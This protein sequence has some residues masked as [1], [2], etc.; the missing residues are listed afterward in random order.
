MSTHTFQSQGQRSIVALP[1]KIKAH[2]ECRPGAKSKNIAPYARGRKVI[3]KADRGARNIREPPCFRRVYPKTFGFQANQFHKLWVSRGRS[4][5]TSMFQKGLPQD[6]RVPSEPVPQTLGFSILESGCRFFRRSFS[7]RYPIMAHISKKQISLITAMQIRGQEFLLPSGATDHLQQISTDTSGLH[8]PNLR[9]LPSIDMQ[10]QDPESPEVIPRVRGRNREIRGKLVGKNH[11]GLGQ[12][13]GLQ[14][15]ASERQNA[16]SEQVPGVVLPRKAEYGPCKIK[17]FGF[18]QTSGLNITSGLLDQNPRVIKNLRVPMQSPGPEK[19][20]GPGK[21]K[22][23]GSYITPGSKRPSGLEQPPGSKRSPGPK[24]TSGFKTTSGFPHDHW[25]QNDLRVQNNLRV[26]K[27]PSG[28]QTTFGFKTTSGFKMTSG[29]KTTSGSKRYLRVKT[30]S[31]SRETSGFKTTS[32]S[33]RNLRVQNDHRV[34]NT[35]SGSEGTSGFPND[36]RVLTEP[37][38]SKG[39]LRV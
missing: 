33:K 6:L 16:K 24:E 31:G 34:L 18:Y 20:S 21:G 15:P 9:F 22:P 10:G 4:P 32:G 39:D 27:E 36:L 5:Q 17:Y 19:I 37:A 7:S 2:R 3:G 1:E 35:T 13:T 38:S 12:D 23:P 14:W 30:T 8:Q 29:F 11:P 25:V 26:Q 28:S